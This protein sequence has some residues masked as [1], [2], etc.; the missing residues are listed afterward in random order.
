MS[1]VPYYF[2][3]LTLVDEVI[4]QPDAGVGNDGSVVSDGSTPLPDGGA[5]GDGSVDPPGDD[6]GGCG[7][8]TQGP[9]SGAPLI[10]LLGLLALWVRRRP[11]A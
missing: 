6:S 11:R 5:A 3:E 7:C 8:Q 9:R 10:L 2:G 4:A 1:K